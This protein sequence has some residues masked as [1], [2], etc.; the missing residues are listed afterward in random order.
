MLPAI[1]AR[2][3]TSLEVYL[4][5]YDQRGNEVLTWADPARPRE[6]LL[7]YDPPTP[8]Y[9]TWW[10]I[11]AIVAGSAAIVGDDRLRGDARAARQDRR[12][13]S[14]SRSYCDDDDVLGP[15]R[16]VVV[17][18]DVLE[19]QPERRVAR[20]RPARSRGS[21]RTASSRA[22]GDCAP[23]SRTPKSRFDDTVIQYIGSLFAPSVCGTAPSGPTSW[24]GRAPGSRSR[25][26]SAGALPSA[27]TTHSVA[28]PLLYASPPSERLNSTHLPS[29]DHDG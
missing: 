9:R 24:S 4:R 1:D 22:A 2:K 18:V 20:I 27:L 7:R 21:G 15:L 11:T 28:L 6:I 14:R 26:R 17:A 25:A 12:R 29:G 19:R 10:G 13:A 16:D 23:T 3:T 8:W 5:A